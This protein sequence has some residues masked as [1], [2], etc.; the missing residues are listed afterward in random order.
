VVTDMYPGITTAQLDELTA[1]IAIDASAV[2]PDFAV[3]AARI[4]ISNLQKE[5]QTD[6]LDVL[7]TLYNDNAH[8]KTGAANPIVT[9]ELVELAQRH[10]TEIN[11]VIDHKRDFNYDYF[12]FKNL[13][14]NVLLKIREKTVERPQ[15]M[16]MRVALAIHGE[17]LEEAFKTYDYLSRH[18]YTHA[19]TTLVNAGTVCGQLSS[20][21]EVQMKDDSIEGIY[22]TVTDCA[23]IAKV[24]GSV[25]M[26]FQKIR[27]S[28]SYIA[29]TNGTSNGII[30]M[31]RVFNDAARFITPGSRK[32]KGT[33]AV[34][35]EPWHADIFEFIE[36]SRQ[37]GA[38]NLRAHNLLLGLW[39]PDLFMKRV[40]QDGEW[41]LMCPNECPGLYTCYGPE[42][43]ELYIRYEKSG[44][45]RKTVS[46]QKLWFSILDAQMESSHPFMCYKDAANT[47]NNQKNLGV[48]TGSTF[49]ANTMQYADGNEI[50]SVNAASIALSKCVEGRIFQFEKLADI[51]KIAV[52]NLDKMIDINNYVSEDAKSGAWKHRA[53]GLGV[54]GLADV[55][56]MMG[57]AYDSA[58]A[59]EL[60]KDI[61]EHIYFAS[62]EASNALAQAS[63]P[64]STYEGSPASQGILQH[65]MW[66]VEG[67]LDWQDLRLK[68]QTYGLRNSLL[69]SPMPTAST[70]V[71]LGN[72]DGIEPYQSMVYTRP[73]HT[74]DRH[75]VNPNLVKDLL[76]RGLW[77][78]KIRDLLLKENGSVQKLTQIPEDLKLMYKNAWEVS[79]RVL[80]DMAADRAAFIDQ[81]QSLN[82]FTFEPNYSRLSS[83]HFYAWKKGLKTGMHYLKTD[84]HES[85][86]LAEEVKETVDDEVDRAANKL[87]MACSLENPESC[88]SC[89]G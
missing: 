71:C 26:S 62:L 45:A 38:E 14:K 85:I 44:K 63:G 41:S 64:Y 69:V 88:V 54:Q 76:E 57:Y 22:D 83:M 37:N 39:I 53:I 36:L 5:T 52:K 42:F 11:R 40:E 46:A 78:P 8:P 25:G 82:L 47:K 9:Q 49:C 13:E 4:T 65:D 3:L 30:P 1:E 27:A 20:F 60:N 75:V 79:Q 66:N 18:L 12:G 24:F 72:S 68:I 70:S 86:I 81:S 32:V 61:F 2:H 51:V 59:R 80:I 31:L 48:I 55:F 7:K 74:H 58:E 10:A 17:N 16:F 73:A 84:P 43:E 34:Y 87:A 35:L 33:F 50:G 67:R 21:F 28:G 77:S 6:F 29:G 23:R 15:H 89:S 19:T 56:L